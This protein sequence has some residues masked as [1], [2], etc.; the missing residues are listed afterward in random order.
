MEPDRAAASTSSRPRPWLLVLLGVVVVAALVM[1]LGGSATPGAPASN[2]ARRTQQQ[3]GAT[4]LDP[5]KL[6]VK[7]DALAGERPG[8]GDSDRNPFGF[9]PK[10]PPPPPPLPKGPEDNPTGG[11]NTP[12]PKPDPPPPPITVKF[13]GIITAPDGRQIASFTDCRLTYQVY[14]GKEFA[15]QYRLVKIGVESAIVER[16]DGTGRAPL[17]MSGQECVG[18]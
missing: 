17:P 1:K 12:G 18:R 13:I 8:P 10:P 15:G 6:D 16:I 3:Q 2:P 14:E 11:V 5:A 7:L 4:R 9:K